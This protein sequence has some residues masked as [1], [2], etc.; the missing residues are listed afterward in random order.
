MM[1]SECSS[2]NCAHAAEHISA[3]VKVVLFSYQLVAIQHSYIAN[4]LEGTNG[5]LVVDLAKMK[6]ISV[7]PVTFN[8]IVETGNRLGDIVLTLND[9]G[10]RLPHGQSTYIGIGGHSGFDGFGYSSRMWGLTLDNV[11]SATVV[12]AD[13]SIVTASEVEPR[14]LLG[15]SA[16]LGIA[17]SIEFRTFAVPSEATAFEYGWDVDIATASNALKVFQTWALSGD[18]PAEFGGE[19]FYVKGSDTDELNLLALGITT[20]VE[21]ELYGGIGSSIN[22]VSL[23]DTAFAHRN[24]ALHFPALASSPYLR[25]PAIVSVFLMACYS[26]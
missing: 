20:H 3:V 16:S 25:T 10:R 8:A 2:I 13:G 19:L 23:D 21:V 17:A 15:S 7:E 22:K 1:L 6:N 24:I 5:S 11:L 14:A 9:A 26:L 18:V 12:L 4:G